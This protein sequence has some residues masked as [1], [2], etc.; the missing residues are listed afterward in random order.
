M[1]LLSKLT[2]LVGGGA[3]KE[4]RELVTAYWPPDVS[5]EKKAELEIK[6]LELQ[7]DQQRQ[8]DQAAAE[9][10]AAI[11]E[12]ISVYE[13]TASDLKTIK[14]L[15]PLMLFLRGCQRPV[16]GF[17]TL[18]M[19]LQWFMAWSDLSDRQETAL[20]AIN[21]LVLGFLFGERAVKNVGPLLLQAF[22][23]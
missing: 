12:R 14:I 1:G 13:G 9:A 17:A 5:P 18:W 6:M 3:L 20:V 11:N 8:A 7:N 4:V 22:K 21:I 19:D 15:G 10:E 23:K 16:W 2:G